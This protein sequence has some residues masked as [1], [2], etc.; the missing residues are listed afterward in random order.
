[1]KKELTGKPEVLL[2]TGKISGFLSGASKF[3]KRWK[4]R[5]ETKMAV[6]AVSYTHLTLPTI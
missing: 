4:I 2:N 3:L 1:M 5:E 6:T